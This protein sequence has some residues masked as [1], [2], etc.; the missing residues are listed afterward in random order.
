[1]HYPMN[2]IQKCRRPAMVLLMLIYLA[3]GTVTVPAQ[4]SAPSEYQLKAAFLYNFGKFVSW[5]A[6]DFGSN[7]APLVIG[8][9]EDNPFHD[10]LK[11]MIAGKNINGHPVRF[12]DGRRARRGKKLS[13]FICQRVCTKGRREHYW[14]AAWR[15]CADRH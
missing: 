3:S 9:F 13:H 5:P 2:F 6:R 4:E 14:H 11:N 12:P 10:D 15:Q 8:V 7:N 1:M